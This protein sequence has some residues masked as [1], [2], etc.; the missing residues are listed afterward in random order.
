MDNW[1][2]IC[3]LSEK[4]FLYPANKKIEHLHP[5]LKMTHDAKQDIVSKI[6]FL[7]ES[8]EVSEQLLQQTP[9]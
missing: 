2:Q 7:N 9:P 4:V 5:T 6:V 1:V 8:V 3:P